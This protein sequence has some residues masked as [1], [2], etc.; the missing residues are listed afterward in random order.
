MEQDRR[1][2]VFRMQYITPKSIYH[3]YEKANTHRLSKRNCLKTKQFSSIT[4]SQLHYSHSYHQSK[5]N[6]GNTEGKNNMN[7][8]NNLIIRV[9]FF[10]VGKLMGD[11]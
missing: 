3:K 7:F 4:W 5:S 11:V 10:Q 8:P 2:L 9:S 1:G 6:R